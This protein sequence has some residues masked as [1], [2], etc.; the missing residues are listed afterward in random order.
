[1]M[2]MAYIQ[3]GGTVQDYL[4]YETVLSDKRLN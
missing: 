4:S 2:I 3:M 1:M